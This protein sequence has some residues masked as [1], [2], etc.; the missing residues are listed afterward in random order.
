MKDG[1]NAVL[2]SIS[3]TLSG[4]SIEVLS[5]AKAEGQFRTIRSVLYG[6]TLAF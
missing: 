5:E 2:I 3:A 6:E 4:H 1:G